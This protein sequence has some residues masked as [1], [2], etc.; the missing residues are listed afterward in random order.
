MHSGGPAMHR[1]RRHR[2]RARAAK[3]A[4]LLAAIGLIAG[5][6]IEHARFQ[7]SQ[8]AINDTDTALQSE[9]S[10]FG[11]DTVAG[12]SSQDRTKLHVRYIF[13]HSLVPGG[14]H[15]IDELAVLTRRDPK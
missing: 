2:L 1:D 12:P 10:Q 15:S 8:T 4:A 11:T 6:W 5:L 14:I 7:S 9:N 3:G 13:G